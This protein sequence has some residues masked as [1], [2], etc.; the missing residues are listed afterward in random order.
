[1]PRKSTPY[2]EAIH[3]G[4]SGVTGVPRN[5]DTTSSHTS[6]IKLF[7][8]IYYL[9]YLGILAA[10]SHSDEDISRCRFSN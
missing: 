7:I 4:P 5:L 9:G 10:M 3:R 8:L 1:M 2:N 6:V